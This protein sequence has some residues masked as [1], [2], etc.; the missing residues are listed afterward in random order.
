MVEEVA[1]WLPDHSFVLCC[2]GAYASL[3]GRTLPRTHFVSRFRKDAALFDTRPERRPGQRGRPRKKGERLP[4]LEQIAELV[5]ADE[6]ADTV[7]D[8]RGQQVRR[9]LWEL[10]VLWYEVRPERPLLLVI[11]RDPDGKQPDDFFFSTD[12]AMAPETVASTYAGRWS[13]EDANR[14][15]K[16]H[17]GGEDPQ[18]RVGAGPERAAALSLW[19]Y[20]AVWLSY[21]A[22][23]GATAPW[24]PR[25]WYPAKRTPSFADALAALRRALWERRIFDAS[26][27]DSHSA[28][29]P[30]AL[31]EVLAQAA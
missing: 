2:D 26:A 28:K 22:C 30:H 25:P 14:N 1:G 24:Q 6:W 17:L 16:Q 10:P 27:P 19:L 21:V 5:P 13:I 7:I 18:C 8:V 11:V 23:H 3:A 12:L 15:V 29:I 20:S 9:L 4:S 31:I